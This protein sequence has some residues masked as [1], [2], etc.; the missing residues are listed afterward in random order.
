VARHALARRNGACERVPDRMSGLRALGIDRG[1]ERRG[2]AV[3]AELRVLTGVIRRSIVGI[4]DMTGGAA[5]IAIVARLIVGAGK[6]QQRIEQ[7]CLL[8]SQEHGIGPQQR[9][10][11]AIAQLRI[12]T[13]RILVARGVTDLAALAA[14]TLE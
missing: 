5:A 10:K 14:A 1:I 3:V 9:P 8:Q 11:A 7:P 13:A 12:G 2:A 4:N 6:R